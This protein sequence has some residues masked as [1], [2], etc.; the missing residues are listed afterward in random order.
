MTNRE[1]NNKSNG[2]TKPTANL[3]NHLPAIKRVDLDKA[4]RFL[5][6]SPKK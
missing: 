5:L 4:V 6:R 3:P 1:N 2:V